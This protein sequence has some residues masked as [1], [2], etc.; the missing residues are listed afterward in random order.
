MPDTSPGQG[1]G[2]VGSHGGWPA[3][4]RV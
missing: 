1:V 4:T 2:K 3:V